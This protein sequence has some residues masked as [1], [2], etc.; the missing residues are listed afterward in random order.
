VVKAAIE[1]RLD[2]LEPRLATT[3]AFLRKLT[4]MPWDTSAADLVPMREAGVVD[5]AIE[6]AARVCLSF[7]VIDRLAD[8]FDYEMS[9][10]RT[11]TVNVRLLLGLGYTAAVIP[12]LRR[13]SPPTT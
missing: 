4:L 3:L 9:K 2:A 11:M 10:G 6:E 7:N 12:G 13:W 1:G 5:A 8:S